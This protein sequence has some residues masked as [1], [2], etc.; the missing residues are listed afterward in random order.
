MKG[1]KVRDFVCT[2]SRMFFQLPT[3]PISKDQNRDLLSLNF[4]YAVD[5]EA[6]QNKFFESMDRWRKKMK[7]DPMDRWF[8]YFDFICA[9]VLFMLAFYVFICSLYNTT[10]ALFCSEHDTRTNICTPC[11]DEHCKLIETETSIYRD[12]VILFIFCLFFQLF[13]LVIAFTFSPNFV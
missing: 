4:I 5:G 11:S 3:L 7:I 13:V 10:H 1:S 8:G 2:S 9:G 12:I 6:K